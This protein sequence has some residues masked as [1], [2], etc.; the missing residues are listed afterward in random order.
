MERKEPK[1][2]TVNDALA[3]LNAIEGQLHATGAV[4]EEPAQL[5]VIR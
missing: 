1:S 4:D 3:E 2:P 5:N